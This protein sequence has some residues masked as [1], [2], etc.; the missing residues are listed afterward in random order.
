MSRGT[1]T[2]N[3]TMRQRLKREHIAIAV[4]QTGDT[5]PPIMSASLDL[6]SYSLPPD[7]SVLIEAYRHTVWQR[8]DF[9]TVRATCAPED[10][11]LR[12][13][14]A[15]EGLLFRVKIV[16]PG[17]GEADAVRILAQA[18]RLKPSED[19]PR[20]SLLPLDPDPSLRDEVW[21][22]DI[23]E[24]D[25]PLIKV[26]THLV[27][28]RHALARSPAFITLVLPEVL[29]RV[30]RWALEDGLPDDGDWDTPR[31]LWI[32]FGCG[33][34]GQS[35]PPDE[36]DDRE[37]GADAREEWIDQ[38]VTRFCRENRIDRL[39][40]RWWRDDSP[41]QTGGVA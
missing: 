33:L 35:E 6:T 38:V 8:F 30:L 20:R 21:R 29:R 1:R 37:D 7:A 26:S 2:F 34:I 36:V 41:R 22:L 23:D 17:A 27:R 19:G 28:D 3:Y 12:D 25:G 40:S 13:F 39:F 11:V 4:H 9:G 18:D 15:G 32:R 31:G 5:D 16:E 10:R 24:N 14:G